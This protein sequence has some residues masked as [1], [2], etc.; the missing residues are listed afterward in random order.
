MSKETK[1]SNQITTNYAF[2][3]KTVFDL[4]SLIQAQS[5]EFYRENEMGFPV[6]ASSTL[7][8]LASVNT[9]SIMEISQGLNLSH[10][11]TSQRIKM[12]LSLELVEGIND[13]ND[14]RRTL[15]RLTEKGEE[16]AKILDLYCLDAEKAFKELSNEVGVD[17]QSVLN[18]AI[19]ALIKKPFGQR[20]PNYEATYQQ[21]VLT[22]ET[23]ED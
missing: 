1:F 5:D 9:A 3:A 8:L 10:Q 6:W 13:P 12:M 2:L 15:Y 14:K 17:L 19:N 21:R 7:L 23:G 22:V 11:L 18:S 20:F 16:K 4:H